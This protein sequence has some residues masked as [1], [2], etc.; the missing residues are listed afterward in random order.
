MTDGDKYDSFCKLSFYK[1]EIGNKECL[2]RLLKN[3]ESLFIIRLRFYLQVA[4]SQPIK[5]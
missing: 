4:L 5:M 2:F 3:R 1:N